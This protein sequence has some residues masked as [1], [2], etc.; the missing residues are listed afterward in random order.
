[1]EVYKILQRIDCQIL[2]WA[3]NTSR[4]KQQFT[5]RDDQ[6]TSGGRCEIILTETEIKLQSLVIDDHKSEWAELK[7]LI[8]KRSNIEDYLG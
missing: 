3:M 4:L 8:A 7:S 2:A 1:M 5:K 6:T